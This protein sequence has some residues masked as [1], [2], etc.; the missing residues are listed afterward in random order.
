[1][2]NEPKKHNFTT[3][4]KEIPMKSVNPNPWNPNVE[5][6]V[7]FESIK[8]TI[9]EKGLVGT[10]VVRQLWEGVPEYQIINGE[11]R[12]K[13]LKELGWTT[14]PVEDMGVITDEEA[15]FWTLKLNEG[16][17]NDVEKLAKIY[18]Q[19]DAGQ[20]SLLGT[21]AE[22]IENTKNLFKFD[23]AKYQTTDPGIPEGTMARVL[24]LKFDEREWD[25]VQ[26]AIALAKDEGHSEKQ[27]FMLMAM[28]FL[29]LRLGAGPGDT[30]VML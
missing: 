11:H 4:K 16:G 3:T 25:V 19:M 2:D 24:A 12:W 30:H 7:V 10:I 28:D 23:F 15:Y 13:I 5:S 18:E 17:K 9:E 29:Q 20:L 27:M 22:E 8:R 26:K 1:M 21:T 6:K 14:I